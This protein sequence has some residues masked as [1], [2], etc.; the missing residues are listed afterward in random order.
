M[1]NRIRILSS[2]FTD[3]DPG[4]GSGSATC[5]RLSTDAPVQCPLLLIET[6]VRLMVRIRIRNSELTDMDPGVQLITDPPDPDPQHCGCAP[7]RC[8]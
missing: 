8:Y 7:V 2:E 6:G 1:I 5:L 4:G 3:P